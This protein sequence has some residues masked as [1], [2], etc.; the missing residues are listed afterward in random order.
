MTL[1]ASKVREARGGSGELLVPGKRSWYGGLRLAI[2][3]KRG[4]SV[5]SVS[6]EVS[7]L[8]VRLAIR[9]LEVGSA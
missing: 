8:K 9:L 6:I 7:C 1:E 5:R 3:W 2:P 4:R